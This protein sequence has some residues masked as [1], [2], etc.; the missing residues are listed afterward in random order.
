M[1]GKDGG[2]LRWC[3]C[4]L[5]TAL[6]GLMVSQAPHTPPPLGPTAWPATLSSECSSKVSRDPA[7][8]GNN[9]RKEWKVGMGN[10]FTMHLFRDLYSFCDEEKVTL[11]WLTGGLGDLG[12]AEEGQTLRAGLRVIS[13]SDSR[14]S[15]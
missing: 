14:L 1:E 5:R 8:G 13:L 15:L 10:G 11:H 9:G 7:D 4:F 6:W 3:K 12:L 2:V